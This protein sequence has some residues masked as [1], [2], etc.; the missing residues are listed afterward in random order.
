MEIN[1]KDFVYESPEQIK[2]RKQALE[3]YQRCLRIKQARKDNKDGVE[4]GI[5]KTIEFSK[6]ESAI[7]SL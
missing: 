6:I 2:R 7:V 5:S 4:I 3:Y 1:S